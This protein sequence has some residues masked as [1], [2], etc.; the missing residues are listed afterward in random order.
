MTPNNIQ[1]G[2]YIDD[3]VHT[4]NIYTTY[5]T[6]ST[7]PYTECGLFSYILYNATTGKEVLSHGVYCGW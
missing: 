4:F 7:V 3:L 1:I 6:S 2:F 5:R